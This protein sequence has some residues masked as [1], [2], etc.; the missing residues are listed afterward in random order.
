MT[1]FKSSLDS[2]EVNGVEMVSLVLHHLVEMNGLSS[3]E[4]AVRDRTRRVICFQCHKRS[5]SPA[6]HSLQS[7]GL[8]RYT[9][10]YDV[11]WQAWKRRL[12]GGG[13]ETS[14]GMDRKNMA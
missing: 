8:F 4:H 14:G 5:P 11:K 7:C 12:G 9:F 6:T 1:L 10:W 3:I 2:I 13:M